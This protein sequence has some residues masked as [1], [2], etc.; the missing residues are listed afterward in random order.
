MKF[1]GSVDF[2]WPALDPVLAV[3]AVLGAV[4]IGLMASIYPAIMASRL[5]PNDALKAI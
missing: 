5:D 3:N 1:I 2:R 4:A